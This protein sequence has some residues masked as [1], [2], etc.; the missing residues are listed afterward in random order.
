MYVT[1]GMLLREATADPLFTRYQCIVLDEAHERSL[2]TDILFGVVKRAMKARRI[3][4]QNDDS[5]NSTNKNAKSNGKGDG[6]DNESKGKDE[7]I[8]VRM[9]QRALELELPPLHVVV[10]SA[11]LRP[12]RWS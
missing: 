7:L 6:N 11:T 2:Q 1:D 4:G 9:R 8:Q 3:S 5:I 10:M 12:F